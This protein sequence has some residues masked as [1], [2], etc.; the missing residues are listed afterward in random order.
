MSRGKKIEYYEYYDWVN[1]RK[2]RDPD[3][4]RK[5]L[6]REDEHFVRNRIYSLFINRFVF[7]R[8]KSSIP[9]P[10]VFK[11]E[12]AKRP[13]FVVDNDLFT[14][15][16]YK[17]KR[18]PYGEGWVISFHIKDHGFCDER[19][20]QFREWLKQNH[21]DVLQRKMLFKGMPSGFSH[22]K[23]SSERIEKE[24]YKRGPVIDIL[25]GREKDFCIELFSNESSNSMLYA[26]CKYMKLYIDEYNAI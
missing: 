20:A 17:S 13:K 22:P 19:I 6:S 21:S 14:M 23:L 18:D 10:L 2:F 26:F 12:H 3:E 8:F 11:E 1:S 25:F 24:P 16:F 9:L 5:Y 7:S 4:Y 15:L